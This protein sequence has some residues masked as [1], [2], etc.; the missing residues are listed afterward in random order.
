MQE[1]THQ[2]VVSQLN[3]VLPTVHVPCSIHMVLSSLR[4]KCHLFPTLDDANT[5]NTSKAN[6]FQSDERTPKYGVRVSTLHLIHPGDDASYPWLEAATTIRI[7][8]WEFSA[9]LCDVTSPNSTAYL[10]LDI[11]S[12]V[13]DCVQLCL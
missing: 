6:T 8:L 9:M 13:G 10:L 3:T 2:E 4:S 1:K 12:G 11:Y 5:P 7:K